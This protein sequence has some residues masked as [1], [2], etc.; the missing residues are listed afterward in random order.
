MKIINTPL[1]CAHRLS[2]IN[3]KKG[4]W[5]TRILTI[6]NDYACNYP[7]ITK[8]ISSTRLCSDPLQFPKNCPLKSVK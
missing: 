8:P 3:S 2:C 4:L 1:Q 6:C 7:Y 5:I